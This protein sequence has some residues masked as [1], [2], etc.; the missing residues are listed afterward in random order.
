MPS[1]STFHENTRP[2][3]RDTMLVVCS[4][5]SRLISS[6][7]LIAWNQRESFRARADGIRSAS[8]DGR[9]PT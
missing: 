7:S 8:N 9:S 2:R 1:F 4:T 5:T 3:K 6:R